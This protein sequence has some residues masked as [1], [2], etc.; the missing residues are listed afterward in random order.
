M[1]ESRTISISITETGRKSTTLSGDPKTFQNGLPVS[2][3][4]RSPRMEKHGRPKALKGQSEYCSRPTMLSVSWITM[5][6]CVMARLF[7]C[8]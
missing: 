5:S 4:R 8:H 2:A 3:N 6:M 7:T 1:L